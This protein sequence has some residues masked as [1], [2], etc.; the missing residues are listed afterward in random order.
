MAYDNAKRE[1]SKEHLWYVEIEVD[2]TTYR[3]VENAA[4]IPNG[5]EATP[6]LQP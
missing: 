3:F 1:Y 4:P 5:L 2:G 6:S